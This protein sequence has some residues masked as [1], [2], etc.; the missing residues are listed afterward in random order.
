MCGNQKSWPTFVI[1][2]VCMVKPQ[3]KSHGTEFLYNH[4]ENPQIMMTPPKTI[5][6][7]IIYVGINAEFLHPLWGLGGLQNEP[8]LLCVSECHL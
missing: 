5:G 7:I 6:L 4:F 1:S 3:M 8:V 2:L